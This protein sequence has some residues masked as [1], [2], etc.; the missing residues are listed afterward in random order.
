MLMSTPDPAMMGLLLVG[1][2]VA[3][4]YT[5]FVYNDLTRR[6]ERLRGLYATVCTMRARRRGVGQD[7]SRGVNAAT[8]HEQRVARLGTRRGRGGGRLA[9]DIAN[10]W[11]SAIAVGAAGQAMNISVH[12]HDAEA[13]AWQQLQREAEAYN[14]ALREFPR[15]VLASA[16]GFRP[17]RFGSN[18]PRRRWVG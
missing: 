2:I 4:L 15:C 7:T 11:P 1:M 6:R 3:G 8:R 16:L 13:Q 5:W 10:G 18:K 9:T 17:W 12:S 14:A